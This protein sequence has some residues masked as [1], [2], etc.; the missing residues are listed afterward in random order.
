MLCPLRDPKEN[1]RIHKNPPLVPIP[2]QLKPLYTLRPFGCSANE[3]KKE[4][5]N[6][7]VHHNQMYGA[8]TNSSPDSQPVP[9]L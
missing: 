2:S 6:T 4:Y 9:R 8:E 3:K 5:E 1:Y 7:H